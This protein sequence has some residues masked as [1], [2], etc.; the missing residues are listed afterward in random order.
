M[1]WGYSVEGFCQKRKIRKIEKGEQKGCTCVEEPTLGVV[2]SVNSHAC[3]GHVAAH[4]V[5]RDVVQRDLAEENA[6][7]DTDVPAVGWDCDLGLGILLIL[8]LGGF[9]L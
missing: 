1:P 7:A 9:V 2:H 5:H 6:L 8:F 4:L 3:L